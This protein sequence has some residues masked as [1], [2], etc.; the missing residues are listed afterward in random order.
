M[1]FHNSPAMQSVVRASD[2][3]LVE[4]NDTFLKK[5]G[6]TRE[7]ATIPLRPPG[8]RPGLW[9]GVRRL[10]MRVLQ[11]PPGSAPQEEEGQAAPRRS[12]GREQVPHDSSEID[13]FHSYALFI[14]RESLVENSAWVLRDQF[15]GA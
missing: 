14:P 11:P 10:L 15:V 8:S 5:L 1:A 7:Q 4:V 3:M 6:F 12:R 13:S 2:A 9:R